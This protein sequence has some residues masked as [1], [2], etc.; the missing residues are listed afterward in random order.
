MRRLALIALL[1][2]AP[3]FASNRASFRVGARVVDSTSVSSEV[4][5]ASLRLHTSTRAPSLVQVG[6]SAPVRGTAD[7]TIATPSSGDVVV[8]LLY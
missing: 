1:A 7:Q 4:G 3:V 2:A 8:T 6:S 5:A